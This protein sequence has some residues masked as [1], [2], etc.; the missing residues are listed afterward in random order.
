M[1]FKGLA[2]LPG[3]PHPKKAEFKAVMQEFCRAHALRCAD[4][5]WIEEFALT[6]LAGGSVDAMMSDVASLAKAKPEATYTEIMKLVHGVDA[7][8][9]VPLDPT[10]TDVKLDGNTATGTARRADG[11]TTTMSFEQSPERGWAIV[12]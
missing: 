6:F 5:K 12:E 10:L 1:N 8:M 4:D 7:S 3:S 11:K 2:M 9:I